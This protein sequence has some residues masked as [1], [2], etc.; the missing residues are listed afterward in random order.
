MWQHDVVR[1]GDS[2]SAAV[3]A[4]DAKQKADQ[5]A[6]VA[7]W[8]NKIKTRKIPTVLE[9]TIISSHHEVFQRAYEVGREI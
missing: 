8:G 6:Y 1:G 3:E 4:R 7:I 5:R 2:S 9:H